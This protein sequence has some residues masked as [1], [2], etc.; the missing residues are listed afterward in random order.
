MS[1]GPWRRLDY[2]GTCN[3]T[4]PWIKILSGFLVGFVV[5]MILNEIYELSQSVKKYL[6]N[7]LNYGWLLMIVTV[8]LNILPVFVEIHGHW[9]Y[10]V[11]AVC[12]QILCFTYLCNEIFA[13]FMFI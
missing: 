13:F 5:C 9:Q 12:M 11:A 8:S 2:D 3:P 7:G 1:V 4:T 10:V 6:K